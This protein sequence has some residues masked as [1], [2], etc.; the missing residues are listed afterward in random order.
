MQQETD[1][2]LSQHWH[3]RINCSWES[4]LECFEVLA[5]MDGD[6]ELHMV[7]KSMI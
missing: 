4:S 5:R 1:I 7:S 6:A 2:R 3:W